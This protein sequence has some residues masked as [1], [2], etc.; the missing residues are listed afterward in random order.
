MRKQT[1]LEE[2]EEFK[3]ECKRIESI[4]KKIKESSIKVF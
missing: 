1:F 4:R 3:E 2:Y